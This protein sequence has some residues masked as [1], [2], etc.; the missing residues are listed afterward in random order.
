[1]KVNDKMVKTST[2]KPK[3]G[4]ICHNQIR[5]LLIGKRSANGPE[6]QIYINEAEQL[7][8]KNRKKKIYI[9]LENAALKIGY[10]GKEVSILDSNNHK[11]YI[12]T[13]EDKPLHMFRPDIVHRVSACRSPK[14]DRLTRRL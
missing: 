5:N 6:K 10:I 14:I 3:E 11:K 12:C 9:I 8:E 4:K 2:S 7:A 13:K 1:M